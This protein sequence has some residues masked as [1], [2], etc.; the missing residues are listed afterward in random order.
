MLVGF[1]EMHYTAC[2][3]GRLLVGYMPGQ[4]DGKVATRPALR[5]VKSRIAQIREHPAGKIIEGIQAGGDPVTLERAMRTAV[6]PIGFSDGFNAQPPLGDVLVC[7]RRAPALGRRGIESTKIDV[8]DVPGAQVGSEV[9]LL[10]RQGDEQITAHELSECF[11][12][13]LHELTYRL[14]S[15]ARRVYIG[16]DE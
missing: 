7:G 6:V 1:P 8:T 16:A 11:G 10:G 3:P 13:A 4:W 14:A 2:D 5:A 12:L 9:V 15:N